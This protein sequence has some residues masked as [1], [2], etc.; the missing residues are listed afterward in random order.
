M[1]HT[2][3]A[4]SVDTSEYELV[5]PGITSK[6]PGV[7]LA[8]TEGP[9]PYYHV[10]LRLPLGTAIEISVSADKVGPPQDN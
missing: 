2:E 5:S 8:V 1:F 9:Q 6:S 7:V 10:R 4:V 3:D